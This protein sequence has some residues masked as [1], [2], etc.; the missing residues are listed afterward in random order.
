[1]KL[2]E[3]HRR[4]GQRLCELASGIEP[5]QWHDPTPCSEWD[6]R[7]LAH[8][9][10]EE[11]LW[12]PP[13]FDGQTIAEVGDR[14]EGDLM[15]EDPSAWG[16]LLIASVGEAHS[17]VEQPGALQRVVHLSYGD[18]SGEEYALQLTADLAIHAW[19]LA[20][21][22]G[23]V[24]AIDPEAVSLLLPWTEANAEMLTASGMFGSPVDLGPEVS[25]QDRLLGLVGRAS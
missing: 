12:V 8:H 11:Q 23:Q 16:E 14:F 25:D 2:V 9:L 17:S 19:D 4:C 21:A 5:H 20:R 1:M 18:T 3:L 7:A 24:D 10:L 13:L 6:V 22:T 15:G